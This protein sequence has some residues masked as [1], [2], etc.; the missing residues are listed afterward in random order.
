MDPCR[1]KHTLAVQEVQA[2]LQTASNERGEYRQYL[3]EAQAELQ[4]TRT[5]LVEWSDG[6]VELKAVMEGLD[7]DLTTLFG[8]GDYQDAVSDAMSLADALGAGALPPTACL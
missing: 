1:H 8:D 7:D 2:R 3:L 4:Q 5:E 6:L